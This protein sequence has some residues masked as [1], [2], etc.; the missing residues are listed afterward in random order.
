MNADGLHARWADSLQRITQETHALFHYRFLWRRLGEITE[1]ANLPPSVIFDAL[2]VWY[3]STLATGVRRQVDARKDALSLRRLLEDLG[4][5]RDV[6]TRARYVVMWPEP[7]VVAAFRSFDRFSNGG[8]I[9]DKSVIEADVRA[10]ITAIEPVKRHVDHAIAHTAR[11]GERATPTYAD[12]N[13][14]IDLIG[15]LVR[16]YTSFL[17]AKTIYQMEPIIQDDWEAVFRQPWLR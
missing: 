17:E 9:L 8:D 11:A 4:R 12:L 13:A 6:V 1:A 16:K 10:L 15:E 14:A 7:D 5:N 2:G 3:A